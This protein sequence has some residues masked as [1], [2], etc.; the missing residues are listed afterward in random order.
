[1]KTRHTFLTLL[2]LATTA[3]VSQAYMYNLDNKSDGE[4]VMKIEYLNPN[5]N[6]L[7]WISV[8]TDTN[9]DGYVQSKVC[10]E[11]IVF[12]KKTGTGQDKTFVISKKDACNNID[13]TV[14]DTEDSFYV[15]GTFK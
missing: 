7:E 3:T 13:F 11:Q 10:P 9:A 14:S 15:N 12:T 4:I 2:A 5:S 8:T 6:Q 1:M